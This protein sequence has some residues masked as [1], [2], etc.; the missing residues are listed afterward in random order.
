MEATYAGSLQ[1][2]QVNCHGVAVV[3]S[4]PGED[5]MRVS[6]AGSPLEQIQ[7]QPIHVS[8][9]RT[10]LMMDN[11]RTNGDGKCIQKKHI[12]IKPNKQNKQISIPWGW[13]RQGFSMDSLLR[14]F[15]GLGFCGVGDSRD[16]QGDSVQ[17]GTPEIVR[18][19]CGVG[20]S[21]DS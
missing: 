10:L 13:T 17:S 19:K 2:L 3:P 20:I 21:W 6:C 5:Q 15:S 8:S 11:M 12:F 7:L 4:R 18:T 16:S 1:P 9:T 14:E